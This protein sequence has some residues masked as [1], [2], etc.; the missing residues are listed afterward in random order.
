M[1][2]ALAIAAMLFASRANGGTLHV[3]AENLGGT[4]YGSPN[5][6]QQTAYATFLERMGDP[7]IALFFRG[8]TGSV[9]K[10]SKHG[11]LIGPKA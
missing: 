4:S 5:A 3:F 2:S 11:V 1:V 6:A 7:A 8:F 10:S 9:P